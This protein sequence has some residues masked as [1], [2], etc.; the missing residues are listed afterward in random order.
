MSERAAIL[1]VS[2]RAAA[3]RMQ[4]RAGPAATAFVRERLTMTADAAAVV[5]DEVEAIR[6]VL[7]GWL[8][9]ADPPRLIL[10]S[11]GT[12][13]GPRDLTPEAVSPLIERPA[14]QLLELA[15]LR[16]LPGTPEAYLSRGVAGVSGRTLILT[17]PGSPRAVTQML[18][19]LAD[20]L[21][22]ALRHV[23]GDTEH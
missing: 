14:P 12:G 11:G 10:T 15:R 4:D 5:P 6:G 1:T 9:A 18:E 13:L 21:P 16:C 23:A 19:Q 17:L 20:L 22:H 3:G 8:G 2:D 7:R